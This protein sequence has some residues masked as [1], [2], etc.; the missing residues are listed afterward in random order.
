MA[1]VIHIAS[2]VPHGPQRL[3][4]SSPVAMGAF[5]FVQST[6]KVRGMPRAKARPSH[7]SRPAWISFCTLVRSA[8]AQFSVCVSVVPSL[9]IRITLT[10]TVPIMT[11]LVSPNTGACRGT[12]PPDDV[13]R[14]PSMGGASP[15]PDA[16]IAAASA[17]SRPSPVS[18]PTAGAKAATKAPRR[19][20]TINWII[21]E[22]SRRTIPLL[23]ILQTPSPDE[24]SGWG[25]DAVLTMRALPRCPFPYP[26][27]M[28]ARSPRGVAAAL[29]P[30]KGPHHDGSRDDDDEDHDQ[31]RVDPAGPRDGDGES[32]DDSRVRLTLILPCHED[33]PVACDRHDRLR[34]LQECFP[35]SLMHASLLKG[36]PPT[37]P[38]SPA[39]RP[40]P[41]RPAAPP[42]QDRCP[43]RPRCGRP[44]RRRTRVPRARRGP[45]RTPDPP[46]P[47]RGGSPRTSPRRRTTS[48]R[49][50]TDRR[51]GGPTRPRKGY[52]PHPPPRPAP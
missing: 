36:P 25:R 51:P 42:R 50:R 39:P 52:P 38:R 24:V 10:R 23:G 37:P 17:P 43:G 26:A 6:V 28:E 41:P 12:T 20:V 45:A 27:T 7:Q 46:S 9:S 5:R 18:A 49:R 44:A 29:P 8:A 1:W 34:F 14:V 2:P 31:N 35:G 33:G 16:G 13:P 30:V 40:R 48:P 21:T 32:E 47:S 22:R 4:G 15:R 11:P 19:T 3:I